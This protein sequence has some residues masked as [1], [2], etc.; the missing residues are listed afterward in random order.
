MA[1]II[2]FNLTADDI[3]YN[4]MHQYII[5]RNANV[6]IRTEIIYNYFVYNGKK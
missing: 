5:T 1:Y 6:D 2:K 4:N 3:N